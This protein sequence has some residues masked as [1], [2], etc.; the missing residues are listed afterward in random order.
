LISSLFRLSEFLL[1]EALFSVVHEVELL[2]VE[3][4]QKLVENELLGREISLADVEKEQKQ[5]QQYRRP[6]ERKYSPISPSSPIEQ[7]NTSS[8][9]EDI[10]TDSKMSRSEDDEKIPQRKSPMEGTGRFTTAAF[11]QQKLP[12]HR[13]SSSSSLSSPTHS[14]KGIII[15]P[16]IVVKKPSS[17]YEENNQF[18]DRDI[19]ESV[20]SRSK[21]RQQQ[22]R[23]QSSPDDD[24]DDLLLSTKT[25][26]KIYSTDFDES[27]SKHR[28]ISHND[29]DDDIAD[30]IRSSARSVSTVQH[31]PFDS[32]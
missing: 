30:T 20:L 31:G 21:G 15:K 8:F 16:T 3:L 23:R 4:S 11:Q 6:I 12:R 10:N 25:G 26:E 13:S 18:S 5:Q 29:D 17:I 28:N 1:D 7:Y 19:D 27:K 9:E 24:D 32:D 2:T 22:F 14:P